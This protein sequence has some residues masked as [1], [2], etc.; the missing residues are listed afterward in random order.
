MMSNVWVVV[1][2]STRCRIFTQQQHN[3]P[4][5]LLDE[6]SHPEG[7]LRGRDLNSD[8][9]GRSFDSEGEGRHAMGQP[10]DPIEQENIRFAKTVATLLEDARR[11]TQFDRLALVVE[12]TFLGHLRQGL[13]SSTRQLVSTELQK[14][15]ADADSETI[16]QALPYRV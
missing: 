12:P 4:L 8:R 15:L 6:L 7:R 13:S 5:E 14:N 3:G 1:A 11:K 16:R 9:A 2:S 10:V